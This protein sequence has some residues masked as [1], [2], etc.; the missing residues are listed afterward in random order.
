MEANPAAE[1]I[2]L[3]MRNGYRARREQ[4]S[5]LHARRRSSNRDEYRTTR[6]RFRDR[7]GARDV[8]F[9]DDLSREI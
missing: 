1:I 9:G 2:I 6:M 7:R 5:L 3:M 8:G 4:S